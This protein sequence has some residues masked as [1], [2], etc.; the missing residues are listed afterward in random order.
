MSGQSL[1]DNGVVLVP[2]LPA[3]P[4]EAQAATAPRV[5]REAARGTGEVACVCGKAF[6]PR[7]HNARYCSDKCKHRAGHERDP[8][9]TC[10][11]CGRVFRPRKGGTSQ[12]CGSR[13]KYAQARA[14][15][16]ITCARCSKAFVH[17]R[18]VKYCSTAC[19][20]AARQTVQKP[21]RSV[22]AHN[23]MDS[24]PEGYGMDRWF[25]YLTDDQ[26]ARAW[27]AAVVEQYGEG[28][29]AELSRA[30]CEVRRRL[31]PTRIDRRAAG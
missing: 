8:S 27:V 2:V 26:L 23:V 3:R 11:R 9:R 4:Y 18:R 21:P 7:V 28:R 24:C 12:Y 29:R 25:S 19:L 13:C 30:L 5:A 17:K 14:Q 16:P 22:F 10:I 6:R 15:H 1:G 20:Y 31:Y